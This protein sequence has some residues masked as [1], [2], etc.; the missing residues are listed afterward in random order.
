M[1]ID[2]SVTVCCETNMLLDVNMW[3]QDGH[4]LVLV[5]TCDPH[6]GHSFVRR[7]RPAP[8]FTTAFFFFG[9]SSSKSSSLSSL[10]YLEKSPLRK[11]AGEA[12]K[13][14][15]VQTPTDCN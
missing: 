6:P 12:V 15:R 10:A 3:S 7:M 9:P 8:T 2:S 13:R 14:G 5:E 11:G 4:S 1:V